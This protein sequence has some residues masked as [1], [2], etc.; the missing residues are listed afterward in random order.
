MIQVQD[1][2]PKRVCSKCGSSQFHTWDESI[3]D[4]IEKRTDTI[5]I[6]CNL[7]NH[8]SILSETVSTWTSRASGFVSYQMPEKP[9]IEKF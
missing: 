5:W 4:L 3:S 6:Q 9:L 2:L 1:N 8:K 7:C